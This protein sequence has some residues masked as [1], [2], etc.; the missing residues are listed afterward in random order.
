MALGKLKAKLL[1]NLLGLIIE[2][3][4]KRLDTA[5]VKTAVDKGLDWIE[6]K[7]KASPATWD[8]KAILPI[9]SKTREVF[10]IPDND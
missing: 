8:D 6:D 7:V 5:T 1:G 10:D 9:C 2:Q 3:A 4:L